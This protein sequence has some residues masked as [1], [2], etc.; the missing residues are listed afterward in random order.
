[1]I[2]RSQNLLA[3][4]NIWRQSLEEYKARLTTPCPELDK[5]IISIQD[6]CGQREADIQ[7]TMLKLAQLITS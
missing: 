1:M 4:I 7:I 2:S 3:K 5:L 6:F